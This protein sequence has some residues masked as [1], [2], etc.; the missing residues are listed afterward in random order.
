MIG[1]AVFVSGL[2]GAQESSLSIFEG[3]RTMSQGTENAF[4]ITLPGVS[5]KMVRK[6]WKDYVRSHFR[7]GLKYQRKER[8]YWAEQARVRNLTNFPI[9]LYAVI[10]DIGS[11]V[12]FTLWVDMRGAYVESQRDPKMAEEVA[13]ILRDFAVYVERARIE[14]RLEEEQKQLTRLERDMRRLQAARKRY[15]QEIANAEARIERM[16]E[17]ILINEDEQA[18][19]TLT[20]QEQM[21]RVEEVR[22]QLLTINQ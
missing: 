10:D 1:L 5:H 14:E 22:Q 6:V 9:N 19:V 15:I 11:Q 21:E 12:Q 13:F 3:S 17:N 18:T 16:K 20:L 2:L 7:S 8:E 4:T